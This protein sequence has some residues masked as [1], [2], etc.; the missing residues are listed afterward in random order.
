MVQIQINLSEEENKI[1]EVFK[2]LKGFETKEETVKTII[3]DF[4]PKLKL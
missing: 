3:R 1:V 4:K 2:A